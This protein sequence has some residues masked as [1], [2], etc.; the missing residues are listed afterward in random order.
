MARFVPTRT[1]PRAPPLRKHSNHWT[2]K[3]FVRRTLGRR[4]PPLTAE[5][6][7]QEGSRLALHLRA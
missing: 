7:R 3:S 1:S 5:Q 2:V 6:I 4:Q